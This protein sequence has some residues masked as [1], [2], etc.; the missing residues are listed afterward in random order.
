ME[1]MQ[2]VNNSGSG[3]LQI[4]DSSIGSSTR[5]TTRH[6]ESKHVSDITEQLMSA[7]LIGKDTTD[8]ME[9]VKGDTRN[10]NVTQLP[11]IAT[12]GEQTRELR[13]SDTEKLAVDTLGLMF[14]PEHQ[15]EKPNVSVKSLAKKPHVDREVKQAPTETWSPPAS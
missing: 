15:A 11:C 7:S 9:S 14:D 3:E 5:S 2:P 13:N 1:S 4:S 12:R 8:S 6:T 10:L